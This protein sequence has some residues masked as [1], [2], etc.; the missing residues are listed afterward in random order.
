[1]T[2]CDDGALSLKT[3]KFG[4]FIGCTNYPECKYTR[5]L[6]GNQEDAAAGDK[7]LGLDPESGLDVLLRIGRFGPYIQLGEEDKEAD[8]KPK[9]AGI[10]K[11]WKV[12]DV[13][14]A[15]ALKL[16]ELP[17][18]VGPHPDDGELITAGLGRYGPF[19][20]CGKVYATLPSVEDVFEVG[21]NRAI[22]LIEEKKANPRAGRGA[23]AKPLREL[24]AH[25]ETGDPVNVMDGRYGP[26]V[27]HQK[28]NATLP[29]DADPQKV[30]LE[31]ALVLI[32][33][34]EKKKPT[35]KKAAKKATK[36]TA[37]KAT[38]KATKK[39]ATKKTAAKKAAKKKAP[40]KAAE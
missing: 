29:K 36:K 20:K 2:A 39:P 12:E 25:P 27:K 26:Y 28:T 14:L 6:G 7:S 16:L 8:E 30:T 31:E 17:R 4:A 13:D 40:P 38:K 3:G 37:K 10:P 15:Q 1:C 23:T 34:R 18:D 11:G 24:G 32:A 21:L 22:A 19:V 33:E 9:R 35:K 5:Q